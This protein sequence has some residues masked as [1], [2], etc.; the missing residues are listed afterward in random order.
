EA[1]SALREAAERGKAHSA[2]NVTLKR[3]NAFLKAGI[4]TEDPKLAYFYKGYDGELTTEAI[5]AAATSA[6]F[7]QA[8]QQDPAHQANQQ[9]E[10]RVVAASA[11]G[12]A[13]AGTLAA[14]QQQMAEALAQGG[15][16]ALALLLSQSGVPTSFEG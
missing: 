8:Q 12:S 5:L 3:E 10:Q 15:P 7:I 1:P 2:E 9:A 13:E 11:G 16:N 6:G 4:N 14:A